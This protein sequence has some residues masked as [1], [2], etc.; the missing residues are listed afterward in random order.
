MP[1]MIKIAF[2][3]AGALFGVLQYFLT[4]RITKNLLGRQYRSTLL[5][6]VGKLILY[7]GLFL[8]V[9]F[10]RDSARIFALAGFGAGLFVPALADCL[11]VV[12][13]TDKKGE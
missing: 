2:V 11:A 8:F 9:W 4:S 10:Y 7:M 3:I 12:N 1:F 6:A 13:K 5:Y